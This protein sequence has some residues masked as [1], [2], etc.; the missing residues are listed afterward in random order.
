MDVLP[1]WKEEHRRTR[2]MPVYLITGE[3]PQQSP[4]RCSY[5]ASSWVSLDKR[6]QRECLPNVPP[7]TFIYLPALRQDRTW[8]D[9]VKPKYQTITPLVL[10][11]IARHH[12]YVRLFLQA[13]QFLSWQFWFM[14]QLWSLS[15]L[16]ACSYA[17]L[18]KEKTLLQV[19]IN[20]AKMQTDLLDDE[21]ED[22]PEDLRANIGCSGNKLFF[23]CICLPVWG[24]KNKHTLTIKSDLRKRN[25]TC[26]NTKAS[27]E[28]QLLLLFL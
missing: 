1:P 16:C 14:S 28:R 24:G 26:S 5:H 7:E 12:A 19:F 17:M 13:S 3:L 6:G 9:C 8:A 22:V 20:F 21:I 18:K 27:C 23:I 4:S 25:L 10:T 11:E 15:L 2:M